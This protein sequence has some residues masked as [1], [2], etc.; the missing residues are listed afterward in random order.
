MTN[1]L[2]PARGMTTATGWA[3]AAPLSTAGA[4]AN[5]SPKDFI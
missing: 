5:A 1:A 4:R 2:A 3:M